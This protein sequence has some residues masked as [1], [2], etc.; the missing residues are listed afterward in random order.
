METAFYVV[1]VL[2]LALF[3]LSSS[4]KILRETSGPSS[5]GW[6]ASSPTRAS[7]PASSC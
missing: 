1:P 4:V 7:G 5:S 6:G 2:I 3:I